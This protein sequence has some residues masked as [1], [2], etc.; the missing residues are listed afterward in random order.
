[1]RWLSFGTPWR[2]AR[3]KPRAVGVSCKGP[4]EYVVPSSPFPPAE[5]PCL[6]PKTAFRTAQSILPGSG[7]KIFW[8]LQA[9]TAAGRCLVRFFRSA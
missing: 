3:G 7:L 8:L 5:G 1:M 6:Q 9:L 2:A 4:V